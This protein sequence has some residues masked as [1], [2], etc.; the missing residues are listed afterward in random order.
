MFMGL[1]FRLMA[2]TEWMALALTM[3][4]NHETGNN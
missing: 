2:C 4:P 3:L 1:N